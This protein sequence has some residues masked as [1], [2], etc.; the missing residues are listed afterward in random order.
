MQPLT[1]FRETSK[2]GFTYSLIGLIDEV[3]LAT[4]KHI[5]NLREKLV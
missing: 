1:L 4:T 3:L 2:S 5:T